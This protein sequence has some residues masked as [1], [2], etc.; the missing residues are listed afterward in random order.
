MIQISGVILHGLLKSTYLFFK[1]QPENIS[2][3]HVNF[4][5]FAINLHFH[6]FTNHDW[7]K[8]TAVAT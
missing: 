1:I 8:S 5:K 6:F 2:Y 3:I 7:C 4:T